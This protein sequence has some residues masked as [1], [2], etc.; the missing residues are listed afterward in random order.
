MLFRSDLD[1][2]E[3][4]RA[5][6]DAAVAER[7]RFAFALDQG[8][9]LIPN[10]VFMMGDHNG[11]GSRAELPLHRVEIGAFKLGRAP[12]TRGEFAACVD[13]GA[14][15]GDAIAATGREEPTFPMAGVSWLDAQDYVGWLRTRTGEQYR[16]PSE[17]EW[18]YAAR[19]G[20]TTAYPWGDTVDRNRANCAGCGSAWDRAG[21]SPVASFAPNAFGL[22]DVV[23]NV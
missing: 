12:V 9:A 7:R 4:L 6:W 10:G 5:Q 18:E 14:C 20:A 15:R 22:Y 13:A 16:L 11:G 3:K 2:P 21:P 8:M 17:A 23:G 1:S 19:A